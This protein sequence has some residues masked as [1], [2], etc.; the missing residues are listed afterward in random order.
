[1]SDTK[2][3]SVSENMSRGQHRQANKHPKTTTRGQRIASIA[4]RG[5]RPI[6]LG[7][8]EEL[9]RHDK[10]PMEA[11]PRLEPPEGHNP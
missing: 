5:V 6:G 3:V 10:T 4:R 2:A 7:R 9:L 1:M 8:L 11:P